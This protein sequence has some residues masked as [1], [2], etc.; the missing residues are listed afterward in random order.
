MCGINGALRLTTAAPPLDRDE[1]VRIREHQARRGP[2]G[3]GL[4]ESPDRR[5]ALAH[6]RL[7]ILDL[8]AAG[9]QP[10]RSADGRYRITYNGELYNFRALRAE[11]AADGVRFATESD[12]E[13]VLALYAR[14]GVAMFPRLR[15]MYAFALWDEAAGTLLLTRDPFGI[16]PL[17]YATDGG[18]LRFASQ[19][20]ALMAGGALSSQVDLGAVAG[21]LVWGSVPEPMTIRAA[22]R[23]LPAGHYLLIEDGR[24]GEPRRHYQPLP[25]DPHTPAPDLVSLAEA[26]ADSVT[27]HLVS[28]VPV[29][30]FLSAGLDS[31]WS[32]RWRAGTTPSSRR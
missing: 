29:A 28:D 19:V 16:K 5:V 4:W 8:S 11:L 13:V 31:G 32:P 3:A 15:G 9:A 30:V 7:A 24:V 27:A 14:E 17:Y 12:T 21:F 25:V 6:N 26:L 10:M 20:K 1:V 2:D 22:V 23:A 18:T